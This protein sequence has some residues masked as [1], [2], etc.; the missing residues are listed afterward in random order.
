MLNI[1][2]KKNLPNCFGSY[3]L[4]TIVIFILSLLTY[5]NLNINIQVKLIFKI[6]IVNSVLQTLKFAL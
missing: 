2:I 3:I 4:S 1:V 6:K 5:L